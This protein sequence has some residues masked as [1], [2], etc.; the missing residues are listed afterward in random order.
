M[1]PGDVLLEYLK[2]LDPSSS[3]PLEIFLQ[4]I[5]LVIGLL[6]GFLRVDALFLF[7]GMRRKDAR[8]KVFLYLTE[9]TNLLSSSI[10]NP[11][12]HHQPPTFN[13]Y[14]AILH[15]MSF[16]KSYSTVNFLYEL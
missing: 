15:F 9:V 4:G 2:A 8:D 7:G 14:K 11:P 13:Y 3:R 10:Y 1:G 12:I 5:V 6:S 16:H